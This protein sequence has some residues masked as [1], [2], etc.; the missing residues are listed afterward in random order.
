MQWIEWN[1]SV[2]LDK[3]EFLFYAISQII[4][5]SLLHLFLEYIVIVDGYNSVPTY[6]GK[7]WNLVI[8]HCI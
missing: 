1:E 4:L 3:S 2:R 7:S 8:I 5:L 6:T